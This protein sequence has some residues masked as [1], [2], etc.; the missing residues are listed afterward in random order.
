MNDLADPPVNPDSPFCA[1]GGG[2]P[3]VIPE[4]ASAWA[5]AL[6]NLVASPGFDRL[7]G[8]YESP[9]GP[10]SFRRALAES[11]SERCGWPLTEENIAVVN[12]SQQAAFYL[13]NMFSGPFPDG[14]SRRILLPVV[15][16][17][18]GY[19]D[20]GLDPQCFV[21]RRPSIEE[22]GERSFKYRVDLDALRSS[23]RGGT[24]DWDGLGAMLLSRPTNP[25]GNVVTDE[26]VLG[27]ATLAKATGIPLILDNAYGLPFP[28]IVFNGANPIWNE[29]IILCM[30][31][32]KIGLPSLRTGIVVARPETI[33]ALSA[34]NAVAALATGGLGPAIAEGLLRSGELERLSR[35]VVGPFYKKRSDLA[36]EMISEELEGLPWSAHESEG[37]IFR[38]LWLRDLPISSKELYRRLKARNVVVLPG[39]GFFFG[40]EGDWKH[41]RECLRLNFSGPEELFRRAMMILSEELRRVY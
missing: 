32:S 40:L 15:P 36:L 27:L 9:L 14:R 3:A 19:A 26:E 24:V 4:L 2:N 21:G 17:Y 10:S 34:M 28:G 25:T 5:E 6:G 1:L 33:Q 39:E 37:A 12:G 16:E 41:S 18:V 35:E 7:V 8:A 29:D 11:F 38:W 22:R 13:I 23:R 20:Q 30:S 31:L